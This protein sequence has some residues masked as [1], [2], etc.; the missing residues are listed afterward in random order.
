MK[1]TLSLTNSIGMNLTAQSF[2]WKNP[3]SARET[4][5]DPARA[6]QAA[7]FVSRLPLSSRWIRS[8][9]VERQTV[10]TDVQ[11]QPRLMVLTENDIF[12]AKP[13]SDVVLDKLSLSQV[14]FVGKVDTA[15][16][17]L[18]EQGLGAGAGR[19]GLSDRASKRMSKRP[20][21]VKFS[22][23]MK[24]DSIGDLQ[25]NSPL[26]SASFHPRCPPNAHSKRCSTKQRSLH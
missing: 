24:M 3:R 1:K 16:S 15:Q 21:S 26:Q 10:S 25:V 8:G 19:I 18:G 6:A 17:A 7:E 2:E 13:E 20:N 9:V 23:A 5:L 11:W 14:A 12:F 4:N 22:T